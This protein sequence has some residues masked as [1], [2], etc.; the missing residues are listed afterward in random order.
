[1]RLKHIVGTQMIVVEVTRLCSV[2]DSKSPQEDYG[3]LP[4]CFSPISEVRKP[5]VGRTHW[6]HVEM[7]F[8]AIPRLRGTSCHDV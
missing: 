5:K 3:S 1:M 7:D 2:E 8:K 6:S 4:I